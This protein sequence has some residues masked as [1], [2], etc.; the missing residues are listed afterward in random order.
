MDIIEPNQ[1]TPISEIAER[2]KDSDMPVIVLGDFCLVK[3]TDIKELVI[4]SIR[5]RNDPKG[6]FETLSSKM[7]EVEEE[8][9]EEIN[10]QYCIMRIS[11]DYKIMTICDD[12]I[13]KYCAYIQPI[14]RT[15]CEIGDSE[16]SVVLDSRYQVIHLRQYLQ[17][18]KYQIDEL[19]L[20]D[21]IRIVE[22]LCEI[23]LLTSIK[24][25]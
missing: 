4:D 19:S 5:T 23:V 18:L 10:H 11:D 25:R 9:E 2:V 8:L 21:A 16:Y 6:L 20:S 14:V 22:M 17:V 12:S 13:G 15:G 24:P 1:D 3:S 7:L